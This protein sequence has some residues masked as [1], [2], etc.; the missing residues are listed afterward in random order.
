MISI[1]TSRTEAAVIHNSVYECGAD[2]DNLPVFLTCFTIA[3]M[4]TLIFAVS[5]S[6]PML[7]PLQSLIAL[8]CKY[9]LKI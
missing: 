4:G 1:D 8:E 3:C 6:R 7:F 9:V 5:L 2:R